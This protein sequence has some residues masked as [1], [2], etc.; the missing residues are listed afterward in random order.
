MYKI[1]FVILHYLTYVDTLKCIE[2]I[3]RVTQNTKYN[4]EIVVVDNFSNNGSIE[5]IEK[6]IKHIKNIHIIKNN[7]NLGFAKGNN[8][9]YNYCR[10]VLKCN[11]IF[12]SNNDIE[13]K[14]N[15]IID[16]SI[17]DFEK[18]HYAVL[19]PDI[20]SGVDGHHQNPGAYSFSN[21]QRVIKEIIR[22]SILLFLSQ[23]N[24]Y[25]K[26]KVK[27][28]KH[29]SSNIRNSE[30]QLHGAFLIF[31][32]LYIKEFTEAFDSRT[33]LYLEEELLFL[34]CKSKNL[35]MMYDPSIV[36]LHNEDRATQALK[37]SAKKRR[38]FI[39][40]NMIS[41]LTILFITMR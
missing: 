3:N 34:R 26:I 2:S 8:V 15:N 16:Q 7:E 32:P 9:G 36:V 11:I 5:E 4:C 35:K 40:K 25:D 29:S 24:L 20:I 31:S 18:H 12:I 6:K 39:F 17:D 22:Y 27:R 19:G 28:I 41:S 33:F 30:K 37:N 10:N 23:I 38:E 14:S 21:R 1:G 13:I